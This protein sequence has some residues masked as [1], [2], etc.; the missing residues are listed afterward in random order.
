[1]CGLLFVQIGIRPGH[2]ILFSFE[3]ANFCI[4]H[5]KKVGAEFGNQP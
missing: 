5:F 4:E 2:K 1:M 3:L